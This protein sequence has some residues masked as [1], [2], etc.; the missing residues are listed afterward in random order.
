VFI[1]A[2]CFHDSVAAFIA[3]VDEKHRDTEHGRAYHTFVRK[4]MEL[5]NWAPIKE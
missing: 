2:G 3:A 1:V 4:V 5:A